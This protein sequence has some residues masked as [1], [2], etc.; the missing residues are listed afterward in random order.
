LFNN[1]MPIESASIPPFPPLDYSS[2]KADWN[3]SMEVL[4]SPPQADWNDNCGKAGMIAGGKTYI[5][6]GILA[7][8]MKVLRPPEA[9]GL[10]MTN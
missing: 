1:V 4:D 9:G 3:D 5:F 7:E 6:G 2:A 8:T 10:A